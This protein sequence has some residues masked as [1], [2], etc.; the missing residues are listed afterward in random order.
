MSYNPFHNLEKPE[1]LRYEYSWVNFVKYDKIVD[2]VMN[3]EILESWKRCKEK[4]LN[5]MM[6]EFPPVF[7][8]LDELSSKIEI[9]FELLSIALPFMETL[10]EIIN[11]PHINVQIIDK[12]GFLLKSLNNYN[13][14]RDVDL[15]FSI[16]LNI[17]E[18]HI[19][20]NSAGL[21]LINQKPIE[22]V[23]AEHYCQLMQNNACYAAPIFSSE[24]GIAAVLNLVGEVSSS[25]KYILGMIVAAARAIE[26]EL[27]LKVT[28]NRIIQQNMEQQEI[29]NTVTDGILYVNNKDIITQVNNVMVEMS[30]IKQDD[31]IGK[32]INILQTSPR[33]INIIG[34]LESIEN[35]DIKIN[36]KNKS[37]NCFLNLRYISNNDGSSS[38]RVLVFTKMDEIQKLAIQLNGD[39]QAFF[40]FDD[41]IG[42]SKILM[43]TKE[44][45][46]KAAEHGTRVVIEGE[47]GTGKEMFAQ[48]I[49]NGSKRAK[50][51]FVAVDCGAIPREL[52]ESE[53]FG[54]E[55]GAYTGARK[56][57]HRGKFE[58]AHGGTLF[59]DEIGNMPIDMQGKLLRV[60]QENRIVR[61]GGYVSI[62]IDVQIIVA[63]NADLKREVERGSFREDLLYRLNVIYIKL[64][65][66]RE[67][68]ADIPIL[69][70][71]FLYDGK[72][73]FNKIKKIDEEVIN[74]LKNYDWPGNIRQLHNVVE[75]M[76]IMSPNETISAGF[77][78]KEI[79]ENVHTKQLL[80]IEEIEPLEKASAQYV[81]NA[82]NILQGNVK[83]TAEILDISRATVYRLLK[84]YNLM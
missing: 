41:I 84:K 66:L 57:G 27:Q 35:K 31:L 21:A 26:N 54:Y 53:L 80:S 23:G 52:L 2:D 68:K 25:S 3:P 12:D 59:L 4:N 5:Y 47:S 40:T 69:I 38:H 29:I 42:K 36:G 48:A 62:P 37:Y 65:S 71:H 1:I 58:L 50:G 70:R 13:S 45:A 46:R 39:N 9:N 18:E 33:L 74:I 44:L 63:T 14:I 61:I 51:P 82:L 10:I 77:I 34:S 28:H 55:E 72:N 32:S 56:G 20:T 30:G 22:V 75:R 49:H 16:G 19:G 7:L 83:K 60:L 73:N 76:V 24:G 43:E 78:P 64:P 81:K 67:R 11:E 17:N 15:L 8:G 79:F 6:R